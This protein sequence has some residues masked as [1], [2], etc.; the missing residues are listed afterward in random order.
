MTQ[1]PDELFSHPAP[2]AEQ[3]TG[4]LQEADRRPR[5]VRQ[6][7]PVQLRV[8]VEHLLR[9][10]TDGSALRR[11]FDVTI[12]PEGRQIIWLTA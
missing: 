3:R 7:G 5:S 10:Q 1:A 6:G 4:D 9:R 12:T 11:H 8:A 2:R